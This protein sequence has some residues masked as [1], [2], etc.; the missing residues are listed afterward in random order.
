M[1]HA[2]PADRLAIDG[3]P[4]VRSA[5]WPDWPAVTPT[6]WRTRIAPRLREVYLSGT[7][8]LPGPRARGFAAEFAQRCGAAHG[9][10]TPHGTDALMA[11]LAGVLDLDGIGDGGEV[12]C[13]NYTFIASASA[14]LAVRCR[15][16][17]VDI[18]PRSLTVAPA[19][20]EAAIGPDTVGVVAVHLGGHAADLAALTAVCARHGLALVEDCAQAHGAACHD[21]PVGALGDAGAFS[22]QSSKNLTAGEGGLVTTNDFETYERIASFVDVGRRPGGERWEYPR[23]GWN[24]RPSEYLAA[25]LQARLDRFDE[26]HERRARNAARL[27]G[28]LSAIEGITPP[29]LV[30]GCTRHAWHLYILRYDPRAFGGRGRAEFLAAL[31]AEGVLCSPGYT[32]PLS[33]QPAFVGLREQYAGLLAGGDCP[34][35]RDACEHTVWLPQRVL[36]AAPAAMD[37]IAEA[38]AKIQRAWG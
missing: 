27:T 8:G 35:T 3:G 31:G 16:H 1:S 12:I 33:A 34:A 4:P 26:L 30:H 9:V 21:R 6:E 2:N 5:P 29:A 20:V 13:P 25:L 17:F 10:L 15:V 24:Y 32:L 11:A 14:A 22:F 7:E 36:L 18:D 38:V 28:L 19:A 37:D 23:L